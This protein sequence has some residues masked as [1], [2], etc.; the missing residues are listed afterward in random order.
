MEYLWTDYYKQ[1][2]VCESICMYYFIKQYS[3]FRIINYF[4]KKLDPFNKNVQ[5][6]KYVYS[7]EMCWL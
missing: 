2:H 3:F 7:I 5:L 6:Q 4:S 1:T